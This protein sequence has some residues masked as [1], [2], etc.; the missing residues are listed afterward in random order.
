[1]FVTS[2]HVKWLIMRGWTSCVDEAAR[3]D[4]I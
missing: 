1:M 3:S 4:G 2:E